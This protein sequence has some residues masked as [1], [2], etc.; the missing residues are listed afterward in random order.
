[1]TNNERGSL[2]AANKELPKL[3]NKLATEFKK[4]EVSKTSKSQVN[5]SESGGQRT[6]SLNL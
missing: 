5:I 1:M 6:L 4:K 3:F 2:F